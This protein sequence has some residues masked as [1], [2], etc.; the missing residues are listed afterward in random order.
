MAKTKMIKEVE[1]KFSTVFTKAINGVKKTKAK[2]T[3]TKTRTAKATPTA[4]KPPRGYKITKVEREL[5][6]NGVKDMYEVY[7]LTGRLLEAPKYFVSEAHAYDYIE[8]L[9]SE[10]LKD[11]A[12][13]GKVHGGS[14]ARAVVIETKDLA[15]IH[16]LPEVEFNLA[17]KCD[18]TSVEDTDA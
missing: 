18:R 5:T 14:V 11:K 12:L 8:R 7:E 15:A 16:E 13:A 17:P 9:R 6:F 4:A 2:S 3:T 1:F 10:E